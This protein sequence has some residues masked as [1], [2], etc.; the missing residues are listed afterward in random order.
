MVLYCTDVTSVY[1]FSE[2]HLDM[3]IFWHVALPDKSEKNRKI[4]SNFKCLKC[5]Q[6]IVK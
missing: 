1:A 4:L 5:F 3:A 6:L 2:Q